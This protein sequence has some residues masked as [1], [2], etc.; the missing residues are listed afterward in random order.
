GPYCEGETI[1]LNASGGTSYS[2][3]GPDGF[4]S[5][6]QNPSIPNAS[7]VNSGMYSVTI[8]DTNGCEDTGSTSVTV[9]PTPT[10]TASNG[11]PYFEGDDI[12]LFASGGVSYSWSGPDGFTSSNQNP[13][14]FN[15]T[16]E[17]AGV[18]VVTVTDV[19][20]CT[21]TAQTSVVIDGVPEAVASNG[22]PY[23]EGEDIELFS[24]GG[25]TYS[26]SG[27]GGFTSSNQ[28]P[29]IPSGTLSNAGFYTVTVTDSNGGSAT[30]STE[31]IVNELPTASASNDGPYCEGKTINLAAS[32]GLIYS[33]EGPDGFS[34]TDQNPT[35]MN[36]T[37]SM[38]GNYSVT[39]TD[40]NGCSDEATT[41][42]TVNENPT[43][44]ASNTGPYCPGESI[45]LFGTGGGEYNWSG[46]EGFNSDEQNPVIPNATPLNT[47]TYTLTITDTN[48]CTAT[49]N[50]SVVVEDNEPPVISCPDDLTV[51]I[52][53]GQSEGFANPD[54]ATA[55]DNCDLDEIVNTYNSGGADASDLYPLG[56]TEV[57][58]TAT[59]VSGNS[60]SCSTVITVIEGPSTATVSGF[61]NR[62]NNEPL[63]GVIVNYSGDESGT[64]ST[65]SDGFFSFVVQSGASIELNPDRPTSWVEF[66]STIDLINIQRHILGLELLDN[67]YKIIAADVN[68]DN[69]VST[70]DLVLLQQLIV[71]IQDSI[72]GNSS[73]RFIPADY[74]F[75]DP[76][77]P[78]AENFPEVIEYSN[79][80]VDTTDNWIAVKTGDV[81][82][83]PSGIR[84]IYDSPLYLKTKEV[85]SDGHKHRTRLLAPD[86]S[87]KVTGYQF[88]LH[89]DVG[90]VTIDRIDINDSDLPGISL[91]HFFIDNEKGLLRALWYDGGGFE[92]DRGM[93]LFDI[94]W[95]SARKS[96]D[97]LSV[98]SVSPSGSRLTAFIAFENSPPAALR[99]ANYA[100]V[101]QE[102]VLLNHTVLPNPWNHAAELRIE[103]ADHKQLKIELYDASGRL[104]QFFEMEGTK[105]INSIQL[106]NN[107][108]AGK[109]LYNIRVDEKEY[110]GQMIRLE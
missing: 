78:L 16:S 68:A 90:E 94:E 19:N 72:A 40:S 22:G 2:W 3:T 99:I 29:V 39:V 49:A 63:P 83:P 98:V 96:G 109:M 59:D 21:S 107:L 44:S 12:E 53:G 23:C 103:L 17:N 35:L 51:S 37:A 18:Y 54:P 55:V 73:W 43:A 38:H 85:K 97:L 61:F 75:D 102:E 91:D 108:P 50:T 20:G 5:S 101:G 15:S 33:W 93:V 64:Q 45:Q 104:V 56:S 8:T 86:Q 110:R 4:S 71:G 57:V 28:N 74:E 89:F 31:V 79:L 14:I 77:N 100:D 25:D 66:V 13:V 11:G 84:M 70:F 82:W 27:P 42:V 52:P 88:E 58:F 9:N 105:G 60:S 76:E 62:G 46:P 24:D 65:D 95:T 69:L 7:I 32:G 80:S 106:D 26:W 48:G 30:A 6:L 36:A 87:T 41:H 81:T 92:L 10:A 47:G 34:S 67:P 1:Q